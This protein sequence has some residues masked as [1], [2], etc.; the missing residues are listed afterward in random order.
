MPV[1]KAMIINPTKSRVYKGTI[2]QTY[3]VNNPNFNDWHKSTELIKLHVRL[4]ILSLTSPAA[5]QSVRDKII[6][7]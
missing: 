6:S 1:S 5:I 3:L 7:T 2:A 4:D